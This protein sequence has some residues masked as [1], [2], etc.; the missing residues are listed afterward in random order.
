MGDESGLPVDSLQLL[1]PRTPRVVMAQ[2]TAAGPISP[3]FRHLGRV[4]ML[5]S[6]ERPVDVAHRILL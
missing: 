4:P 6:R 3:R 1:L 5:K 2:T